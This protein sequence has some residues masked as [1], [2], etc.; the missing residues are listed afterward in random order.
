MLHRYFLG[1][2]M[3][4]GA[5]DL[6]YGFLKGDNISVLIGG[7]MVFITFSIL[8]KKIQEDKKKQS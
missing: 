3:I 4:L 8:R 5:A 7:L 2:F 6:V 1:F